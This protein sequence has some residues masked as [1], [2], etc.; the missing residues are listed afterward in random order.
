MTNYHTREQEEKNTPPGAALVS[1]IRVALPAELLEKVR[2]IS[3]FDLWFVAERLRGGPPDEKV[4]S[5]IIEFK[6]YMV[7]FALGYED[8]G[9]ISH[10]VDE[11]WHSFILFTEAYTKFCQSIFG[12]YIHHAPNT[13]RSPHLSRACVVNFTD[14]YT[15]VFG[16][17]PDIWESEALE[18]TLA[19]SALTM[20]DCN[21]CPGPAITLTAGDCTA[22]PR[23]PHINDV[24][25]G[26]SAAGECS[27]SGW[28]SVR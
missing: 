19:S 6:K 23:D 24:A 18:S 10:E 22:V 11:V 26:Y 4:E 21:V 20:R 3:H 15:H 13:S 7:L 16:P 1:S 5:S 12:H 17:L 14:A 27:G 9:M 8:L 2:A 25:V 28:D